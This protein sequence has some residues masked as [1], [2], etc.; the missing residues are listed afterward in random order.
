MPEIETKSKKNRKI[1]FRGDF[2][3][4]GIGVT[5]IPLLG[6]IAHYLVCER[7]GVRSCSATWAKGMQMGSVLKNEML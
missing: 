4:T 1:T 6:V 2:L 3:P 7:N 5:L